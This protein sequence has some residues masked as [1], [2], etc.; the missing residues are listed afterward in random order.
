M[1]LALVSSLTLATLMIMRACLA[2]RSVLRLSS[3]LL[4]AGLRV[5]IMAVLEFPPRLSFNSLDNKATE[6]GIRTRWRCK[7]YSRK[8]LD[9]M[10][11]FTNLSR[12]VI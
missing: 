5:A 4:P 7:R 1:S 11:Y 3:T 2:Y 8:A 12:N 10:T 9:K 6:K